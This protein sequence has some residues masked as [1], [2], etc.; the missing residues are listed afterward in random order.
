MQ[1]TTCSAQIHAQFGKFLGEPLNTIH[2][3]VQQL[4]FAQA[5]EKT[6]ALLDQLKS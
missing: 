6:R 2:Q 1:S 5:L 3:E 4:Q